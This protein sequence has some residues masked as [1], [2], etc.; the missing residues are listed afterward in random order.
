MAT[1]KLSRRKVAA[2]LADELVAGRSTTKSILKQL[3]AYLVDTKRTCEL[4]LFVRDIE[5]ALVERGV[6]LAD[7][8][9][10]RELSKDTEQAIAKYLKQKTGVKDVHLR[11]SIDEDLLGGVRIETPD[12][13]LDNTI[14]HRINQ[15]TASKI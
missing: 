4:E 11:S 3:A 14:R 7:I 6:L 5:A 9:S 1:A 15:L 10:A 8:A 2:H 13:R 12:Q